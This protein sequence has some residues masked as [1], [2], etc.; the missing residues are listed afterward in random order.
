M[1]F[2]LYI[3]VE[4]YIPLCICPHIILCTHTALFTCTYCGPPFYVRVHSEYI[5]ALRK[6]EEKEEE[7]KFSNDPISVGL[8]SEFFR[9]LSVFIKSE[10]EISTIL[11]CILL[12]QKGYIENSMLTGKQ[13]I[14]F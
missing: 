14:H 2:L 10:V 4:L 6:E 7:R 11:I 12:S 5:L 1:K 9:I 3:C 13:S 8:I